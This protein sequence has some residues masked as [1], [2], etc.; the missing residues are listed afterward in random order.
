MKTMR[1]LDMW[2]VARGGNDSSQKTNFISS[3]LSVSALLLPPIPWRPTHKLRPHSYEK[4][5]LYKSFTYLLTY[6]FKFRTIQ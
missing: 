4:L 5:A 2:M 6:Y 3:R 1:G